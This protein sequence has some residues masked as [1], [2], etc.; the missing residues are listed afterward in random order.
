MENWKP[1]KGL[2]GLYEVSDTG[3]VRSL[4]R[5][6]LYKD[7]RVGIHKGRERKQQLNK[8]GYLAIDLSVESKQVRRLVHRLVAEAFIPNPDNKEQVNH[9]DGNKQNNHVD[10]LEWT[11]N[12]ENALHANDNLLKDKF[13]RAKEVEQVTPEG[14]SINTYRSLYNAAAAVGG[15][16]YKISLVCRGKRKSHKGYNWKFK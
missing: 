6:T 11:T 13:R 3:K 5:T 16:A 14:D 2:E 12:E 7:G 9:I 8:K 10:N 1:I 4:P 15:D